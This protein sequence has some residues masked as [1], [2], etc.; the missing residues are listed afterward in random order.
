MFVSVVF[1]LHFLL[2]F[3]DEYF[4]VHKSCR[5]SVNVFCSSTL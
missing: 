2:I 4:S 5:H 1:P 3:F